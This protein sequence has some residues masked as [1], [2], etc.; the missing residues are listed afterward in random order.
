MTDIAVRAAGPGDAGALA[1]ILIDC[2][3]GGASVGFLSPL[4]AARAGAYWD[5][6]L[7]GAARGERVVL[8]A[9][10]QS[11][12]RVVGTGQLVPAVLENQPHRADVSK[13]LVHRGARR[14]GVGEALMRALESAAAGAG[15][16]V[17]VLDTATAEAERL[18]DRLGW[19]RVGA[20]PDYAMNPDATLAAT[21]LYYKAL[22]P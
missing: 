21:T 9:E 5:G 14:R 13:V 20:I 17:L 15:R 6:V 1:E 10:E 12:G 7:A 11:T 2:V 4:D 22:V 3:Q 16:T 8:V 19:Q 18:Y